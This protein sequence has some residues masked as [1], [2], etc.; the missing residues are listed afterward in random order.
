MMWMHIAHAFTQLLLSCLASYGLDAM[1]ILSQCYDGAA[2]MNGYKSG[3]MKRLQEILEKIIPYIH[4]FNHR[5]RLVIIDTVKQVASVKQFFEQ[6]QMI[7]TAFRKPKIRKMYEGTAVKRLIDT[8]WT[9][10]FQATKAVRENY[11]QIVATL[12]KVKND[13]YNQIDLDGDDI[14]TC[15]GILSVITQKTFVFHLVFMDELLTALTPADAIF[16]SR[17]MSYHRAMPVV[18]IAKG[19]I[20]N[21]RTQENLEQ[22]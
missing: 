14:A 9:G 18:E 20:A 2:V 4:C 19:T 8:R 6:I 16:Q 10:H 5:L 22:F 17:E 21:Y 3:V 7:Y 12:E 13:K 15:I 11:A 1:K